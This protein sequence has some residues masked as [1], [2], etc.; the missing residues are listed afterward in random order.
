[1]VYLLFLFAFKAVCNHAIYLYSIGAQDFRES[2]F[3][4]STVII[5]LTPSAMLGLSYHFDL[6]NVGSSDAYPL[7]NKT[8]N[9]K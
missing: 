7:P 2:Q 3:G 9:V 6:L 8:V 1:M 5:W 4:L